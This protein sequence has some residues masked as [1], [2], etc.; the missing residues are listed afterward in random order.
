MT[1][2]RRTQILLEALEPRTLFSTSIESIDGTGNNLAHPAWGAA[3]TDLLRFSPAAYADGISAPAGGNRPSARTVS[4]NISAQ[5]TDIANNRNLTDMVYVFGQFLDHDLDLTGDGST[6]FNINVPAGDPYFDPTSTGTQQI[7]LNR[8]L[9]DPL[10]GTSTANPAQQINAIT[11]FIDGSQVY[12][13]DPVRAAALR[14]FSGG[15]LKTSAGD[16]LPFNT[17][18]L[19]N[20]N[21]AHL[22]PD[23]QLFLAGDVRA[24]EN[25]ELI[26][27][28]TLFMREHNRIAASLASAH[29]TWTDEQLYQGARRLVIAEIQ[30]ITVNEFLPAL[31]GTQNIRP[32]AGYNPNVDPAIATEFSTVAY[33]FGH[34]MLDGTVDRLNNDGSD[35]P[36]GS[37]QLANAFFNP[38]LLDPTLP[39]NQGNIDPLLKGSISGTAQEI[40]VK[41]TDAVRNFLFGVPGSGGFDLAALNIQRGRDNG[42]PDYNTLR[43]VYGLPKVTSFA[44]IT[45]D[46]TLQASLKATY[47]NVN[48]VDPWV[49][50]LAENHVP[51]SSLGPLFGRIIADQ[52]ARTRDGDR[53]WFQNTFQGPELNQIMHTTLADIIRRNTSLTNV[54]PDVFLGVPTGPILPPPPPPLL[55][56]PPPSGPGKSTAPLVPPK[57]PASP[58]PAAPAPSSVHASTSSTAPALATTKQQSTIVQLDQPLFASRF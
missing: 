22:V 24:N 12:G 10:T 20:A 42:L 48:S 6:P 7:Y 13:S 55:P 49:G 5:S 58:K 47:G 28:Q 9:T 46:P 31:L 18:G 3:N 30:S 1:R 26:A 57:P 32:Y 19:A 21:D 17:A 29:P 25:I 38:A 52:F 11:S 35:I 51:G 56:P 33:R 15:L 50:G 39:N 27:I 40:D 34:S 16:L 53:F 36:E 8:S 41:I 54:Q 14:T 4:N 45:S 44:Q 37:V 23:S 2:I 43:A